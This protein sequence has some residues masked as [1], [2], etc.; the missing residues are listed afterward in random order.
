MGGL[1]W[2][3]T[4]T[5]EWL[6]QT[7]GR[8][9]LFPSNGRKPSWWK[10]ALLSKTKPF[11]FLWDRGRRRVVLPRLS[12]PKSTNDGLSALVLDPRAGSLR[13]VPDR[14]LATVG[15]KWPVSAR[16]RSRCL[17]DVLLLV[18]GWFVLTVASFPTANAN[19]GGWSALKT[20]LQ[21]IPNQ[22]G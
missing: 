17:A 19:K 18:F 4:R 8:F 10:V 9:R 16:R 11:W 5:S 12:S 1:S 6:C 7:D 3:N 22:S 2:Q 21:V 15:G 20:H 13:L 14:P